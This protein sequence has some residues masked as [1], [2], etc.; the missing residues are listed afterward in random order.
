M[1]T[2]TTRNATYLTNVFDK[3]IRP[4]YN[5]WKVGMSEISHPATENSA[6][7]FVNV[8]DEQATKEA[9]LHFVMLGVTPVRIVGSK[10]RYL[11]AYKVGLK[12]I[13]DAY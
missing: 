10:P 1:N 12:E 2:I 13:S 5:E 3:I 6:A 11:Y 9:F 4:P 7:M 8:R